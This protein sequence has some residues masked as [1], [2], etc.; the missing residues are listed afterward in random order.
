M[1]RCKLPIFP[2]DFAVLWL[3]AVIDNT[4]NQTIQSNNNL[5]GFF[6]LLITIYIQIKYYLFIICYK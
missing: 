1:Q 5:G 4:L 2:S 3:G 6:Y